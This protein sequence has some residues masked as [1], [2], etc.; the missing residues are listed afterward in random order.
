MIFV[1]LLLAADVA[2]P[3]VELEMTRPVVD[4]AG[5]LTDAVDDDL[6]H[7]IHQHLDESG[8]A[9]GVLILPSLGGGS[10]KSVTDAAAGAFEA[11]FGHGHS[12]VIVVIA[13]QDRML[14]IAGDDRLKATLSDREIAQLTQSATDQFRD[15]KID[16]AV[17]A[18]VDGIIAKTPSAPRDRATTV[19]ITLLAAGAVIALVVLASLVARAR[20]RRRAKAENRAQT[21]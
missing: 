21:G 11:G 13:L 6:S 12:S 19:Q 14:R 7:K 16:A 9:I 20:E 5:A 10:I 3:A 18:L 15:G 8:V 1:A 4:K 2:P 17:R